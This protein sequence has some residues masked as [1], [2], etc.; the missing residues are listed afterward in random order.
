MRPGACIPMIWAPPSRTQRKRVT[1]ILPRCQCEASASLCSFTMTG[2]SKP[3]LCLG[4]FRMDAA[5]IPSLSHLSFAALVCGP[6][7][8][9]ALLWADAAE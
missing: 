8:G 5:G 2:H 9:C 7:Y 3:L 4:Y 6:N 1:G